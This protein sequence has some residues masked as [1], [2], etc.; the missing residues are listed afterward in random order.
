MSKHSKP[1]SNVVKEIW[2]LYIIKFNNLNRI[3]W[4]IITRSIQYFQIT[5][6]KS[7]NSAVTSWTFKKPER[8][9]TGIIS[10][11]FSLK[12]PTQIAT[13]GCCC[14]VIGNHKFAKFSKEHACSD[15]WKSLDTVTH[16]K[17]LERS[18]ESA[19]SKSFDSFIEL[20]L[21]RFSSQCLLA[22]VMWVPLQ[23]RWIFFCLLSLSLFA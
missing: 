5:K 23:S 2:F 4:N 15:A 11:H 9:S 1:D 18:S 14:L 16:D 13:A 10:K 3:Q 8:F 19:R 6:C 7:S 21:H 20:R 17:G 12:P 22:K